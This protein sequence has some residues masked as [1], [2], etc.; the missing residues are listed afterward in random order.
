MIVGYKLSKEKLSEVLCAR[1][2]GGGFL[3]LSVVPM[4]LRSGC[5]CRVC[6]AWWRTAR[7]L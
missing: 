6:V 3:M 7:R 5:E 2:C 4:L 1:A